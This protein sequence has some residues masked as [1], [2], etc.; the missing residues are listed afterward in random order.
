VGNRVVQRGGGAVLI[1]LIQ[2]AFK[3]MF[4]TSTLKWITAAVLSQLTIQAQS[5]LYV[6][7]DSSRDY[8]L[9]HK[10][11]GIDPQILVNGKP[12]TL[13]ST[14]GPSS[15]RLETRVSTHLG[16]SVSG[17]QYPTTSVE[18]VDLPV[19]PSGRV[20][21][22]YMLKP[23]EEYFPAFVTVKIIKGDFTGSP[24]NFRFQFVAE[25]SSDF[26]LSNLFFVLEV[27]LGEARQR[28]FVQEISSAALRKH[29]PIIVTVPLLDIA[30][31][32]ETGHRYSVRVFTQGAELLQTNSD[33]QVIESALGK[34][35][36]RRITGLTNASPKP[37]TGPMPR[38]PEALRK[39][40]ATGRAV[41]SSMIAPDG[42]PTDL[43][44]K[45][46]SDPAFAE[47]A[48]AVM[49]QWWFLPKVEN[50][51]PVAS[52]VELPFDFAPPRS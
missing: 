1:R 46:A 20:W 27:D 52:K 18:Q 13:E 14:F 4:S 26:P 42:K 25:I 41:V 29:S 34:I 38:Y 48:L 43:V 50:G 8:R 30:E 3:P 17:P 21:R 33:R 9:V 11:D 44:V 45:N 7:F 22:R 2:T 24:S 10:V 12:E 37:L 32:A 40:K 35:V 15:L 19:G 31:K 28:H 47:A 16:P 36:Q 23:V 5:A 49:S 39:K 51:H 6:L